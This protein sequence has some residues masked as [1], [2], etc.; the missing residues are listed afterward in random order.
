METCKQSNDFS[1]SELAVVL[2]NLQ[3]DTD[4]TTWSSSPVV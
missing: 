2:G 3:Y 1:Y 4:S